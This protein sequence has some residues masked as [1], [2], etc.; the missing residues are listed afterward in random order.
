M[1]GCICGAAYCLLQVIT[2]LFQII[3]RGVTCLA[4]G[5]SR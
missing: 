2:T 5:G 4:F 3:V 1:R